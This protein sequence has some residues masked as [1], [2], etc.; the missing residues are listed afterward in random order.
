MSLSDCANDKNQYHFAIREIMLS[1][2][3]LYGHN[4]RE[5]TFCDAIINFLMKHCWIFINIIANMTKQRFYPLQPSFLSTG[6]QDFHQE[7]DRRL[8]PRLRGYDLFP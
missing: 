4:L 3:S 8:D 7:G 1:S 2:K 5:T 6:N